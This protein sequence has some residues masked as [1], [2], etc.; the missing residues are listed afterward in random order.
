MRVALT[1]GI[2]AL[3]TLSGCVTP[4]EALDPYLGQDIHRVVERI[5]EPTVEEDMLGQTRYSWSRGYVYPSATN[6]SASYGSGTGIG[7]YV[8]RAQRTSGRGTTQKLYWCRIEF[9]ADQNQK[10]TQW[11]L[12]K[13]STPSV[14][15]PYFQA[16][17]R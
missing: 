3:V 10:I 11:W 7:E 14:C 4:G 1:L 13:N 5:G 16:L 9:A 8:T 2:T 17:A 12:A 6:A 15:R